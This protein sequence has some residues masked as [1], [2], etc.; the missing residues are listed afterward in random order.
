MTRK[1]ITLALLG[2]GVLLVGISLT[3]GQKPIQSAPL[4]QS[5]FPAFTMIYQ[6]GMYGFGENGKF[7]TALYEVIYTDRYHW[8]VK[9]LASDT[10]P[11]AVGSWGS[12]NGVELR[13]YYA[14]MDVETSDN[15]LDE[16]EAS[17][18]EEIAEESSINEFVPSD[19]QS[20]K[21]DSQ[22]KSSPDYAPEEWLHPSYVPKLLVNANATPKDSD[23]EGTKA[24]VV[25]EKLP[26]REFTDTE[27]EA[28]LKECDKERV[29]TQEVIYREDYLIPVKI[30]VSLDGVPMKTITVEKLEIK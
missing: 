22:S 13:N 20:S 5:T 18:E 21:Q 30:T 25:T 23:I 8:K 24:L 10:Q 26:C 12:Y 27:R 16:E 7:G 4:H 28:G 17:Q 19:D 1:N 9:L 29:A 6:Q 14:Q 11:E 15:V 3:L 2:I